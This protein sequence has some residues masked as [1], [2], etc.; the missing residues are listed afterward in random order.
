[1]V[2]FVAVPSGAEG[3]FFQRSRMRTLKKFFLVTEIESA[4][5]FFY[6]RIGRLFSILQSDRNFKKD[7]EARS[8]KPGQRKRLPGSHEGPLAGGFVQHRLDFL[9]KMFN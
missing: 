1:M 2:S 7:T 8:R 3:A 9:K 6:P 4:V 5:H